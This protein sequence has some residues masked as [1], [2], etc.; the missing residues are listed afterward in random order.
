MKFTREDF[1][2]QYEL[3]I[4]IEKEEQLSPKVKLL[5]Q[6]LLMAVNSLLDEVE[7]LKEENKVLRERIEK[8]EYAQKTSS[9]SSVPPAL[10]PNRKRGRKEKIPTIINQKKTPGGQKGHKGSTLKKVSTPDEIINYQLKGRCNSCGVALSKI[11][12]TF[13][14]RQVFE[15]EFKKKV[16]S[17]RA[18]KGT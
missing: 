10:D 15:I 6:S 1:N 17:H 18:L 13:E 12:S 5:I 7:G 9:N 8:L 16:V 14:E 4:E 3:L 2:T 11:A